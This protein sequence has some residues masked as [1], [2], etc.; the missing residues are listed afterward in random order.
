MQDDEKSTDEPL[1][2]LSRAGPFDEAHGSQG[3]KTGSGEPGLTAR[4]IP[5]TAVARPRKQRISIFLVLAPFLFRLIPCFNTAFWFDEIWSWQISRVVRYPWEILTNPLAQSDNNHPLNTL[6]MYLIG[7]TGNWWLYRLLSLV[8]GCAMALLIVRKEQKFSRWGG[9]AA[10]LL[11]GLSFPLITYS[12]EARGYAPMLLCAV[13]GYYLLRSKQ[14]RAA[15]FAGLCV[16]GFL[17]HATFLHFL[18]AAIVWVFAERGFKKLWLFAVPIIFFLFYIWIFLRHIQIG[19]APDA[20]P[21]KTCATCL[22]LLLGG[23][24]TGPWIYLIAFVSLI[25]IISALAWIYRQSFAETVFFFFVIFLV[26]IITIF[27]QYLSPNRSPSIQV[28]YLLISLTFCLIL[29][30][31]YLGAMMGQRSWRRGVAM[32]ILGLATLGNGYHLGR[33]LAVG[34]GDYRG[35]LEHMAA[36]SPQGNIAWSSDDAANIY[37]VNTIMLYYERFLPAGATIRPSSRPD[38]LIFNVQDQTPIPTIQFGT[39]LYQFDS[40]YPAYGLSGWDWV[41]YKKR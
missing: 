3:G 40:T 38:W 30:V 34:R 6:W 14:N 35:A 5:A 37:R 4:E 24:L 15:I 1:T 28:R 32:A 41:L 20:A 8:T 12:S 27:L 39:S 9:M 7:D 22:S 31:R 10:S 26:P 23:F 18:L 21:F 33:F 11:V 17:A 29:L 36:N 2:P 19:G 25:L 16:I 13:A